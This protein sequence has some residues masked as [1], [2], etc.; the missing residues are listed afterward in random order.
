MKPTVETILRSLNQIRR[1]YVRHLQEQMA[2]DDL[3]PNEIAVLILLANNPH[4]TT[5]TQLCVLLGVSKSL[6][7]RSVERLTRRGIL[8]A[9][10]D[11]QDRRIIHLT[12][13][14]Q[15]NALADR[16]R[17]AIDAI[18]RR[19]LA[20]ISEAQIAQMESTMNQIVACFQKEEW[21]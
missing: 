18:N 5:A 12:I 13:H 11:T 4:I 10:A 17:K 2:A 19:V 6:V 14:P 21:K 1:V 20:D 7:S 15:A 3:S 9:T 16:L 8:C